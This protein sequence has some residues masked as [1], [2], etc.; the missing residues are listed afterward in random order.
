MN[1]YILHIILT[2][3]VTLLIFTSACETCYDCGPNDAYPYFKFT[4]LNKTSLDSLSIDVTR[5]KAEVKTIDAL[6]ADQSNAGKSDSLNGLKSI[7]VDSLSFYNSLVSIVKSRLISIKSINSKL[8]VFQFAEDEDDS[9]VNFQIPINPNDLVSR[10]IIEIEGA[11]FSKE[12]AISYQLVDTIIDSKITKAAKQLLVMEHTF[13][14]LRGP[15]GCSKTVCIS[16][17]QTIYV[18]I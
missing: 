4:V 17:N 16:N 5:L 2:V 6:L 7:K 13:D 11:N 12:L 3:S 14:S 18:E 1:K 10:Y 15:Y 8:N 9:L